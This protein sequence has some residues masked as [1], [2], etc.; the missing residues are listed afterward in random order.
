MNT[1]SINKL[2]RRFIF[3]ALMAYLLVALWIGALI[4]GINA[5]TT[6]REIRTVL[7]TIVTYGG[8]LPEMD[9]DGKIHKQEMGEESEDS[10][11]QEDIDADS[12]LEEP[13]G[14]DFDVVI[15]DNFTIYDRLKYIYIFRE[16][17]SIKI[18]FTSL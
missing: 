6:Q 10:G 11:S 14:E 3:A 12:V 4:Y 8:I 13:K 15:S 16:S 9:R 2:R 5:L 7:N 1:S 17:L 18:F